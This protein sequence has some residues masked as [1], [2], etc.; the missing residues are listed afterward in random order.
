[1]QITLWY[2][3]GRNEKCSGLDT[4]A[5]FYF[6][7][8]PNQH[9]NSFNSIQQ[10]IYDRMALYAKLQARAEDP[11]VVASMQTGISSPVYQD[12][13][14]QVA[15]P[16]FLTRLQAYLYRAAPRYTQTM[17]R[18]QDPSYGTELQQKMYRGDFGPGPDA[19]ARLSAKATA[20]QTAPRPPVKRN[21][22]NYP[23][24]PHVP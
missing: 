22:L 21:K 23:I 12:L 18:V 15:D 4:R 17:A 13:E 11:R 14:D 2:V 1:M 5:K 20:V 9:E 24:R 19:P 10:K 3:L 6:P 16:S 7:A 8:F